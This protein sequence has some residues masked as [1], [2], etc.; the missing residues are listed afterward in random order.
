MTSPIFFPNLEFKT[1]RSLS[2][3]FNDV[4][5]KAELVFNANSISFSHSLNNVKYGKK[6]RETFLLV[7]EFCIFNC[8]YLEFI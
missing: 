3:T 7:L 8:F 6:L 5:F 2:K 4:E 1:F